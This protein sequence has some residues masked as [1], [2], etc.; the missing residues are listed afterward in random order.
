MKPVR[1]ILVWSEN[2]GTIVFAS[3]K[4]EAKKRYKKAY[5]EEKNISA[6]V[7]GFAG[8]HC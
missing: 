1:K 5:P 3:S 7:S 8:L 6:K 4:N 2:Y